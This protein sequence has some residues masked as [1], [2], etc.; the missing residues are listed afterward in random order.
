MSALNPWRPTCAII[1]NSHRIPA[2]T[3]S[4]WVPTSVKNAD[5]KALRDGPAP[6]ATRLANSLASNHEKAEAKAQ[7]TAM[8]NL[9]PRDGCAYLPRS[10]QGRQ[11]KL[12][13]SRKPVSI[14]T[15][16]RSN[17][18]ESAGAARRLPEQNGIGSEEGRR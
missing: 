16:R 12:D 10:G 17:R 13:A 11:V 18:S 1:V 5:R 15:L 14:A 2:E 7:V 4:P 6:C 8:K 3:C 9:V